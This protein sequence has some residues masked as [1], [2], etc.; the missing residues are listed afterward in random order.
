MIKWHH[1]F[2][3]SL[4][5]IEVLWSVSEVSTTDIIAR[6]I[7]FQTRFFSTKMFRFVLSWRLWLPLSHCNFAG[8]ESL[9]FLLAWIPHRW[10]QWWKLLKLTTA[11]LWDTDWVEKNGA[12]LSW[13]LVRTYCYPPNPTNQSKCCAPL[14]GPC[15]NCLYDQPIILLLAVILY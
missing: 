1:F 13:L 2:L 3:L 4:C 15:P 9:Q 8:L 7:R 10:C 11:L 6:Q 14:L 12:S 5:L